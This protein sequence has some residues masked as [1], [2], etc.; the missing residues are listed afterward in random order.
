VTLVPEL[1]E[2]DEFTYEIARSEKDGM[3]VPGRLFSSAKLLGAV[4]GDPSLQQLKNVATLPGIQSNAY[5]MPDIHF[6]YGFPVGGV[7]AFDPAEGVVSPGGIGY[8]I[9]CGV[10]L[11]WRRSAPGSASWSTRSTTRS[12]RAS[13]RRAGS[14]SPMPRSTRSSPAAPAGSSGAGSAGRPTSS[15]RRRRGGSPRPTRAW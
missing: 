7:A 8:D 14:R 6:G 1:V 5:A 15:S 9:N 2:L 13:A 3:R 12:P 10:R 4:E 11:L